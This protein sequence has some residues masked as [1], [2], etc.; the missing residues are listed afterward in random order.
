[1]ISEIELIRKIQ[2]GLDLNLN[3]PFK[4]IAHQLNISEEDVLNG[5]NSLI[6]NKKI[7]RF[8]P[9]VMNRNLG[10]IH[11]AMVVMNV[12]PSVIDQVGEEISKFP[13]VTLCYQRVA[14][15]GVWDF[16]LYFMV[17]GSDREVVLS[18]INLVVKK[19]K[20]RKENMSILFSLKCFKQRGAN[21]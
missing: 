15:K 11:N 6:Q 19:I 14:I 21:Y 12:D 7:K 2:N 13:F 5:I 1:M 3:R 8:G 18:Q 10:L 4:K 17:H 9:V 16:N 20:I